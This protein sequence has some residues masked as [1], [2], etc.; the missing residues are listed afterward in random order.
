MAQ[1]STTV[2][3]T[4]LSGGRCGGVN[5]FDSP[6]NIPDDQCR[7]AQNIDFWQSSLGKKR[8]GASALAVTFSSG[9]PFSGTIGSLLRFV[10]AADETAAELW[11]IDSGVVNRFARLAGATTWVEAALAAYTGTSLSST[12]QAL[13]VVGAGLN[14]LF[15]LAYKGDGS[16]NRLKVWDPV[17]SKVRF[18]GVGTPAAPTSAEDGGGGL[19]FTRYYRTREVEIS[20][21]DTR[22]RSEASTVI[23]RT[24]AAKA[25]ITVT[26]GASTGEDTTHWELEAADAS[27]GPWYRIA[28][29]ILATTTFDDTSATIAT[30]NPS[31][32]DG[33]NRPPPS[34]QYVIATD[35]RLIMA[36]AH[37]TSG[38]YVRPRTQG[39]YV[40]PVIGD[41]DVGDSERVPIGLT[42][43]VDAPITGLAGPLDG[44]FFVF[45]YRRIWKFVPTGNNANPYARYSISQ[46]VGCV[47]HQSIVMA[48]DENGDPAIYF[49][50]T[51]G[52]YRL[53]AAGLQFLGLDIADQIAASSLAGTFHAV[54]HADKRKV[55][56][57]AASSATT[58]SATRYVFDVRKGRASGNDVRKGWVIDTGPSTT[59][60][61]SV[62]FSNTVAASMSRDL[63][64]YVAQSDATGAIWKCDADAV[65]KDAGTNYFG[66]VDTK[67]YAPFGILNNIHVGEPTI[68]YT[69]PVDSNSFG[70]RIFS[71]FA[72]DGGTG[73]S[74]PVYTIAWTTISGARQHDVIEAME[75]AGCSTFSFRLGDTSAATA[76]TWNIDAIV[77]P[78]TLQEPM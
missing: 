22:R 51:R 40:T 28:Q 5:G 53:G 66:A 45:S 50:S 69:S 38:G 33:I 14:G 78:V 72:I 59:A 15:F 8:L 17:L 6:L 20:G 52:P 10:P 29:T 49:W 31:A 34:A 36:G 32:I 61:A 48:E 76:N 54:Y 9:G 60:Y 73:V 70:A 24:I 37:E 11:A 21:S 46:S 4:D 74:S 77:F 64:P 65:Y 56:F 2:A 44:A 13:N 23:S 62:M 16:V 27:T 3:V 18:V 25:G 71:D 43:T 67:E 55:W 75:I 35:A 26:K 41:N 63:K 30:T 57:F 7:E 68:V 47:R 58:Y 39:I 12:A 1:K 19:S 42:Y